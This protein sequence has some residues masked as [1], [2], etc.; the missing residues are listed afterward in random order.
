MKV[1]LHIHSRFSDRPSEW[2]LRRIGAPE[3]FVE[4][5]D[6]YKICR[7]RGM[8]FV[9][10]TDHN[11]IEGALSIAHLPGTFL[12]SEITTYFPED[13]CKIHCLTYGFS[14]SQFKEIQK[15][16][17][18]IYDLHAYLNDNNIVHSIAHPLYQVSGHL[19]ADHMEKLVLLF[20][21]FE[22]RNGAR[23]DR[24]AAAAQM[25]L[26]NLTPSII[27]SMAER[28]GVEPF[29]PRPWEKF[30]TG[31]SDDHS[32]VYAGVA[33]TEIPYAETQDDLV[34]HLRAG[35]HSCGGTCG[36]SLRLAHSL[37]HIAYQ[38]YTHILSSNGGD[39]SVL[40]ELLKRITDAGCYNQHISGSKSRLRSIGHRAVRRYRMKRLSP[41]E[42]ELVEA[43]SNLTH[44]ENAEA[45]NAEPMERERQ[46]YELAQQ[47][48]Q[49]LGFVFT[50]QF[51]N[52]AK[53]GRMLE[54]VQAL[55]SLA[56]V[57]LSLAPYFTAFSSQNSDRPLLKELIRRYPFIDKSLGCGSQSVWLTDT[58]SDVNG[59]AFS[60]KTIAAH[61][62]RRGRPVQVV[63][64]LE[65]AVESK[66]V[67]IVNFKPLGI[68]PVPEYE[69]MKV[70][71]PP[72]LNIIEHFERSNVGEII[73][74]TP[75]PLG[76]V[77]LTAARL[78]GLRKVG[79]Y[80][81][82]I[83]GYVKCLTDDDNL[84]QLAWRCMRWFYGAMDK[85]YVPSRH[86][87]DL[88]A[89]NGIEKSKLER[90]PRGVDTNH[91]SPQKRSRDSMR[92]YGCNGGLKYLYVG[93]ISREKNLEILLKAFQGLSARTEKKFDLILTGDGPDRRD[94]E[95]RY[96]GDNVVFTGFLHGDEL[97]RIYA[98]ADVFVFPSA[99]DTFGNVVLEA[100]ASGLP[101]I[102]ADKGGPPEIIKR[103]RS[104]IVVKAGD[105]EELAG[106]M[107]AMMDD[108]GLRADLSQRALLTARDYNWDV[109]LENFIPQPAHN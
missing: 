3:S 66:G 69:E 80:H 55:A 27:T 22:L 38:Y 44:D 33:Y 105:I 57:G 74:S 107:K 75:G 28:Q 95:E 31:G 7:K 32:G 104:G 49:K 82:D 2:F 56:P 8:D 11:S 37:Y 108:A 6:V 67:D 96:G 41:I 99:T 89:E 42:R 19:S 92:A 83:P 21:R 9:T 48:G 36:S 15:M 40:S 1:D 103:Q 90:L 54:S 23:H 34:A 29:G 65:E 17:E 81:T 47:V 85:V 51:F 46:V 100:Q 53:E 109:A 70:A 35:R 76:L 50:R 102:V 71:F 106:A 60:I 24:A 64:C 101:V 16:R 13:G 63:T 43:L 26:N 62:S 86:Y 84:E 78:L 88:L 30:Y 93:R 94:L 98:S 59:V 20:K 58:F 14:E 5:Q 39:Q 4:P 52:F 97:A 68:F 77:G 79:I 61:L 25:L 45:G 72:F 12:S 91:F 18:N 73:I 87:M 10:V